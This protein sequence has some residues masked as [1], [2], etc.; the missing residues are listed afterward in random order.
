M[1]SECMEDDQC[2]K[3]RDSGRRKRTTRVT[4]IVPTMGGGDFARAQRVATSLARAGFDVRIVAW[5]RAETLPRLVLPNGVALKTFNFP[6]P[7]DSRLYLLMS[8]ILWWLYVA[9]VL[10]QN[11]GDVLHGQSF[12]GYVPVIGASLIRR[13]IVIYDLIDFVA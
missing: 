9:I 11:P 2:R 13:R 5:N 4:I 1:Q 7:G 12:F 6:N 3:T 10:L 8:Y